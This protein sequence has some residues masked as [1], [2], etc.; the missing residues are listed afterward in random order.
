MPTRKLLFEE[1]EPLFKEIIIFENDLINLLKTIKF[2]V[3]KSSF[4]R[5]LTEGIKIKKNTKTTITLANKTSNIYKVLKEQYEKLVNNAITTSYEKI[6]NKAQDQIN[7]HGKNKLK[8][9]EVIRRMLV[10]GK[11]KYFITSKDHNPNFQNNPIVRLLNP[12]KNELGRIR[13][14]ILDKINVILR[15]SLYL[16]Q[17][18]NTQEV[19]DWFKGIE[20][21]H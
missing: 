10:D 11:Q 2:R 17:W 21:K 13:Q 15:Y 5:Q 8:D 6:S 19:I 9:M 1:F 16:N 4:R 7:N 3:T 12:S 18:K 20:N 14:T